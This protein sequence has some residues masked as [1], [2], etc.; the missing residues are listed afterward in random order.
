MTAKWGI[1]ILLFAVLALAG[2]RTPAPDLKPKDLKDEKI[3][4]PPPGRYNTPEYPKQ[5][6]SPLVDPT[7]DAMDAKAEG[8][9]MRGGMMPGG[10]GMNGGH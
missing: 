4:E 2:C 1:C 8:M 5:A 3:T 6:F 10:G 7:K 9:P